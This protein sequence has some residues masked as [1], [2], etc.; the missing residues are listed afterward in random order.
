MIDLIMAVLGHPIFALTVYPLLFF[1][2]ALEFIE[3]R[4][5]A[6]DHLFRRMHQ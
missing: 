3:R 4:Q 1:V 5:T 2:I 6:R